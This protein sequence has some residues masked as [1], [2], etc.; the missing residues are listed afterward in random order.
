[1][2]RGLVAAVGAQSAKITRRGF[3]RHM[4]KAT[5]IGAV[6]IA[7]LAATVLMFAAAAWADDASKIIARLGRPDK[8]DSTEYDQ[9]RPP[10]VSRWLDYTKQ[11]VRVW[12]VPT[13][14]V[15]DP[16]PYTWKLL[17]FFDITKQQ[18]ISPDE[19]ARRFGGR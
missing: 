16:P 11:K 6:R 3:G 18:L 4:R 8:D 13:N 12:L 2:L 14:R 17:G 9:P 1:M 15:G 5:V 7:L 19:V 10:V